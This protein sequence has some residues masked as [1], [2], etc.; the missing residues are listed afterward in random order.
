[1]RI[2]GKTLITK[3]I[4]GLKKAWSITSRGI[5]DRYTGSETG[6]GSAPEDIEFVFYLKGKKEFERQ[7]EYVFNGKKAYEV[8]KEVALIGRFS[9]DLERLFR[10]SGKKQF[11]EKI[12]TFIIARR[13][14][15]ILEQFQ[16]EAKKLI[17]I[18]FTRE[19]HGSISKD[20]E[21]ILNIS[22]RKAIREEK[23]CGINGEKE[24][25]FAK[26]QMIVGK[27]DLTPIFLALDDD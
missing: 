23:H 11:D 17:D 15:E 4:L 22:S 10:I 13:Q 5:L 2:I 18:E 19:V 24:L 27:K 21:Q 9:E 3:G 16:L 1:M 20:I 25:E 12:K 26:T 8:G 6:F 7:V 14:I